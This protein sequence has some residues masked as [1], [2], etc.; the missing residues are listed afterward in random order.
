MDSNKLRLGK[1]AI[2]F[3]VLVGAVS[4]ISG[5]RQDI[6]DGGTTLTG[7]TPI[8]YVKRPNTISMNPT[9]A[10]GFSS[11]GNLW[12]REKSSPSAPAH[13]IT[14]AFTGDVSDP[15]V[16]YDGKKVLF[17]MRCSEPACG[18]TWNI[19]EY[20]FSSVPTKANG[21]PAIEQGTLRR[22]ISSDTIADLGDDVD[23][24]Y[25]PRGRGI[26]FSS[27]RQT[28][29]SDPSKPNQPGYKALDEYERERVINLHTM[30]VT[31]TDIKQISFNQS[32][33]RNPVV[34]SDGRIMFAR[35]DHVANRNHFAIFKS[36]QDGTDMFVLYGAHSPGNSFLHPREMKPANTGDPIRVISTLMP[37]SGTNEG[38]AIMMVHLGEYS[39]NNEPVVS[40][41]TAPAGQ[42]Q[43]TLDQIPTGRGLS[44]KGRYTTPYPIWD[45][46]GRILTSFTPCLLRDTLGDTDDTNDVIVGCQFG[47]AQRQ[48]WADEFLDPNQPRSPDNPFRDDVDPQ[49]SIR[50]FDI[51]TKNAPLV[52]P[53]EPGMM[54]TDPV[55]L[56]AREEPS[57]KLGTVN[58]SVS[59]GILEVRSV[60]DTDR[61][62][63]MG[64]SNGQKSSGSPVLTAAEQ[65]A[66]PMT[67]NPGYPDDNRVQIPD[68][69][70][71]KDP[72]DVG[73]AYHNRVARFVRVTQ[74]VPPRA[75]SMGIREAI[76]E[77]EFEQQK[78]LGYADVEPDGSFKLEVPAD[79]PLAISVL[80]QKGRAFQTHTNWI[81]VRPGETRTCN[82]CHSPRR[83]GAI[84]T[85]VVTN[86][87]PN[88]LMAG[89]AGETM[90]TTRTNAVPSVLNLKP[91]IT[92][93][94]D[95]T[96]PAT[97]TALPDIN[98]RYTGNPDSAQDLQTPVPTGGVI[99]YEDHIQPLWDR[100]R[101]TNT[102]T[103]GGCHDASVALR[104]LDL[105]SGRSGSGRMNSYDELLIGNPQLDAAG[106]P[107][108]ETRDGI[109]VLVREPALVDTGASQGSVVGLARKSRLVEI[110]FGET[111]MSSTSARTVHPTPTTP[112]PDHSAMLNDAEKRLVTEWV[113]L[114]G[115]YSNNAYATV[116]TLSTSAFEASGGI[117]DRL[118]AR[119][120]SCH[121]AIGS[122]GTANPTFQRSNYVLTGDA[123]GD[124]NVTLSMINNVCTPSQSYL[125]RYPLSDGVA[126]NVVHPQIGTT[127]GPVLTMTDADYVAIAAWISAGAGACP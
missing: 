85:G 55:P 67:A 126:P 35:W 57:V 70:K 49:Y 106:D 2:L 39:E 4:A 3:T 5:C 96:N 89:T 30:S 107:V 42:E 76:G 111:L 40:N 32:H 124:L 69:L 12:I 117:H 9:D 56:M 91:E 64:F 120:G 50:M 100:D 109:Q 90:A 48:A 74:A 72:L 10:F 14:A 102:C 94:D 127:P 52:V 110:L 47:D 78:I 15:E 51:K 58:E 105:T 115:Q 28:T 38:G 121:Q 31:G 83:G 75:S 81:Q 26:L 34:L 68:L 112:V 125:L 88:T 43:V 79:V 53:P 46:S 1:P 63:R 103:T 22:I 95:W 116:N 29:A 108:F 99:N 6:Q 86:G 61:L 113:D 77:T 66:V 17:A 54:V 82:G 114:G 8:A 60:Y 84:N 62:A 92:F 73:N 25:L 98:L 36:N 24:T 41:V 123:E 104:Q 16:S 27:N 87:H 65:S 59:T 13:N 71:I 122:D 19:W 45:D 101:G 93:T 44:R 33:D 11:G 80:D 18:S 37:L 97:A 21:E 118:L 7:D 20:D 23:P 119:C